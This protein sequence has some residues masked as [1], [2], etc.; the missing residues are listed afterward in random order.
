MNSQGGNKCYRKK[1][2]EQVRESDDG[3]GLGVGVGDRG[4]GG[5]WKGVAKLVGW[6]FLRHVD[7][8]NL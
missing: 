3:W 4:A 1:S 6:R 5:Q 7:R 2:L 8:C